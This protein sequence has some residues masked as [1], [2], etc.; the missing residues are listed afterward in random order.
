MSR[1]AYACIDTEVSN[2]ELDFVKGTVFWLSGQ[3]ILNSEPKPPTPICLRNR[4]R[5]RFDIIHSC[6]VVC[7]CFLIH[8]MVDVQ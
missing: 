4:T 2:I 1:S 3:V 8:R 6:M 5:L 7:L